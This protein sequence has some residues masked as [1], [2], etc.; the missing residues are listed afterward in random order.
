MQQLLLLWSISYSSG[1]WALLRTWG[2]DLAHF[3]RFLFRRRCRIFNEPLWL[4]LKLDLWNGTLG[5]RFILFKSLDKRLFQINH[6]RF[7]FSMTSKKHLEVF[8]HLILL[9]N[10]I[11]ITS[12]LLS[13]SHVLLQWIFLLVGQ[14]LH[15]LS[16][17]FSVNVQNSLA[18]IGI[19]NKA[20]Y[21]MFRIIIIN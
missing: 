16:K 20:F 1:S 2:R 13:F 14:L 8:C 18:T 19:N 15:P 21:T 12:G 9:L 7:S 10:S 6:L 11:S 17:L 3:S 5:Q 4:G